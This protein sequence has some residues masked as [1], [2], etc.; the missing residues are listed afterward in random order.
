MKVSQ[1]TDK[2]TFAEI[3][4]GYLILRILTLLADPSALPAVIETQGTPHPLFI[5]SRRTDPKETVTT[6]AVA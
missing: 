6:C 1:P 4:A 3:H 5:R 2:R